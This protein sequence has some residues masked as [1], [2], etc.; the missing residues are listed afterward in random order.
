MR[1]ARKTFKPKAS[2]DEE[3]QSYFSDALPKKGY[4][5]VSKSH[6]MQTQFEY[7]GTAQS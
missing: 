7:Q 1:R 3:K 4:I 5:A 2:H 6:F